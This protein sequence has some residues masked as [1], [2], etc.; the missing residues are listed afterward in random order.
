MNIQVIMQQQV[1]YQHLVVV[2]GHVGNLLL[3]GN[4]SLVQWIG[5]DLITKEN[6]YVL[7]LFYCDICM[8]QLFCIT[9]D[10][11]QLAMY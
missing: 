7:F 1:M 9:T 8:S 11:I 3:Q 2:Y 6:Q 4:L 10:T 5:Q